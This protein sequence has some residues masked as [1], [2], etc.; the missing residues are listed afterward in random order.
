MSITTGRALT[1]GIEGMTCGS[2]K[3]H[4][5]DALRAV[6]GVEEARVD[7]TR[8]EAE[9]RYDPATASPGAIAAAIRGA[10]YEVNAPGRGLAGHR[11]GCCCGH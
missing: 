4:V 2:C 1:L 9:V 8:G 7:L 11:G 5:E 10:G 3:R 6:P